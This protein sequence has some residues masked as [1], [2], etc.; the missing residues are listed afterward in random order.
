MHV[1][2]NTDP[3]AEISSL[4]TVNFYN[5]GKS[6]SCIAHS[7]PKLL[8]EQKVGISCQ[9]NCFYNILNKTKEV[10]CPDS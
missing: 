5:L 10:Y 3:Y 6:D 7:L 1:I 8:T 4:F 9:F 2:A